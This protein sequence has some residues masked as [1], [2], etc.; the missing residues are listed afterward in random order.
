[1]KNKLLIMLFFI[2]GIT[3][4]GQSQYIWAFT[5]SQWVYTN[6]N[7]EVGIYGTKGVPDPENSPGKRIGAASCTDQNGVMWLF[8]GSDNYSIYNDLWSFDN[9]NYQWTWQSGSNQP[10]ESGVFGQIGVSSTQNVIGNKTGAM[11]WADDNGNLWIYGGLGYREGLQLIGNDLWKYNIQNKTW[12]WMNGSS[13]VFFSTKK[14]VYGTM[15][16]ADAKNTPGARYFSSNFKDKNGNLWLFAG[17]KGNDLWKYNI[18]TGLWTWMKGNNA[19]KTVGNYGQKGVETATNLPDSRDRMI[20]MTDAT[21]N[22]WVFGGTYFDDDVDDYYLNDLWKFNVSTNNWTWI[23]G[24]KTF[25]HEGVY[26]TLR[27]PSVNNVPSGRESACGWIN[28]DGNLVLTG[29]HTTGGYLNDTWF[30]NFYT[31]EWVWQTGSD[32]FNDVGHINRTDRD[33]DESTSARSLATTWED[34]LGTL[35]MFGGYGTKLVYDA[36]GYEIGKVNSNRNDMNK[37]WVPAVDLKTTINNQSVVLGTNQVQL[38]TVNVSEQ[39]KFGATRIK[40]RNVLPKGLT[41]L[42]RKTDV[43]NSGPIQVSNDTLDWTIASL[44]PQSTVTLQYYAQIDPTKQTG[45]L[46]LCSD[47]YFQYAYENNQANNYACTTVGGSL[48]Q[49]ELIGWGSQWK[50]FNEGKI[51]ANNWY[52]STYDDGSWKSGKAP[53]G[54]IDSVGV[55]K[56]AINGM[57]GTVL[58]YGSFA[59]PYTTAYFRKTFNFNDSK[60]NDSNYPFISYLNIKRDDGVVVYLNGVEVYRQNMPTGTIGYAT[61]ATQAIGFNTAYRNF[62]ADMRSHTITAQITTAL[63]QGENLLAVEVHQ[64]TATQDKAVDLYNDLIFDLELR[65][66]H[67]NRSVQ[68]NAQTPSLNLLK[69]PYIQLL[70]P[71]SATTQWGTSLKSNSMAAIGTE[72][73]KPFNIINSGVADNDTLHRITFNNLLPNTRYYYSIGYNKRENVNAIDA[74]FLVL[75]GDANNYFITSPAPNLNN[76]SDSSQYTRF[77]ALGDMGSANDLQFRVRNGYQK[78]LGKNALDGILLLGDN[79]VGFED[80]T[81][82]EGTDLLIKYECFDI[83]RDVFKNTAIWPALGNHDYLPVEKYTGQNSAYFKNFSPPTNNETGGVGTK[84]NNKSY[85]SFDYSNAHFIMV[86]PYLGGTGSDK[87]GT[88]FESTSTQYKWLQNDLAAYNAVASNDTTP[89]WLIVVM[90]S[91]VYNVGDGHGKVPAED[92]ALKVKTLS[93][94]LLEKQ[95]VD[96]VLS[97][98][99]HSYQRSYFLRNDT[100]QQ[101]GEKYSYYKTSKNDGTLYA[102]MGS[103][104]RGVDAG[105]INDP[106]RTD[107]DKIAAWM[108]SNISSVPNVVNKGGSLDLRIFN[109]KLEGRFIDEDGMVR[110]SFFIA[111]TLKSFAQINL[112]KGQSSYLTAAWDGKYKWSNDGN[113]VSKSTIV[114]PTQNTVYTISDPNSGFSQK[115]TVN[116]NT[117][118]SAHSLIPYGNYGWWSRV[119]T[120]T[121]TPTE[122][123][124]SNADFDN[125]YSNSKIILPIYGQGNNDEQGKISLGGVSAGTKIMF[126][127][128]FYVNQN[129]NYSNYILSIFHEPRQIINLYINGVVFSQASSSSNTIANRKLTMFT[130]PSNLITQGQGNTVTI[131]MA[132]PASNYGVYPYSLTFDAE[133]VGVVN[134]V[135]PPPTLKAFSVTT[136]VTEP[137]CANTAQADVSFTT[138]NSPSNEVNYVAMLS[139]GQNNEIVGANTKSPIRI[140]LPSDY[141]K[142]VDNYTVQVLPRQMAANLNGSKSLQNIQLPSGKLIGGKTIRYEETDTLTLNFTGSAPFKYDV[143]NIG[144]GQTNDK[145]LKLIVSPNINT[146]YTLKSVENTCGVGK[147]EGKASTNVLKPILSVD[148]PSIN[149]IWCN[150]FSR[151]IT[152]NIINP[153]AKS[154]Q[155]QVYLNS[156]ASG[157]LLVGKNNILPIRITIPDTISERK[158]YYLSAKYADIPAQFYIAENSLSFPINRTAKGNL[159][160]ISGDSLGVITGEKL[161]L[162]LN[163]EGTPPFDYVVKYGSQDTLSGKTSLKQLIRSVS[164]PMTNTFELQSIN[165]ICGLGIVSG[166]VKVT[167][168]TSTDLPTDIS[169][170]VAPNPTE[171]RLNLK[172]SLQKLSNISWEMVNSIG[173]KIIS[174]STTNKQNYVEQIDCTNL[175]SGIYFLRVFVNESL[176]VHKIVKN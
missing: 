63:L 56:T 110:D 28:K 72:P 13:D 99:E 144:N 152:L 58:G 29:G 93:K 39:S 25:N 53:L 68:I 11:M 89:K 100:I 82:G 43:Y 16:V 169:I 23:S 95:G 46:Q 161:Q 19:A 133:L 112:I 31:Q 148:Q 75:S 61:N 103:S 50:Y 49:T 173:Q 64:C 51:P 166:K 78:Y 24:T 27:I 116:V 106:A 20:G 67:V 165:N 114:S 154:H 113:I 124:W 109:T 126:K 130:I 105:I 143:I 87:G 162:K 1:M 101:V 156:G 92:V 79:T 76:T 139:N 2:V 18:Q 134:G 147:S 71:Y 41:Y 38:I 36:K 175:T 115:Y 90:H 119:I 164:I 131:G 104:G 91:P 54:Y 94:N 158:D 15:G 81:M 60:V 137:I 146:E 138:A 145:L 120:P 34:Q 102:V 128:Y 122:S 37:I 42:S 45:D 96:F 88:L 59:S 141:D 80:V 125:M 70:S 117:A 176:V 4:K 12:T 14:T 73:G 57:F 163:L 77:W 9:T 140:Q 69:G 40:V 47:V 52:Q 66:N 168:I 170:E 98:H 108:F 83:Y 167:L 5:H 74:G 33:E 65:S 22:F 32:G 30:Y 26:G 155:Y 10:N 172:L 142:N 121:S 7:R 55:A 171:N 136:T 35:W 17:N 174:N 153:P 6:Y 21:G 3:Q 111:K 97:S 157:S 149:Q 132:I 118:Q 48:I 150:S 123:Q 135:V 44:K 8:G 127:N 151:D 86:D 129:S 84:S 85:Y 160:S 62:I 107:K 159:T